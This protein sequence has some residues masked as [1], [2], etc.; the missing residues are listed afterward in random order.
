MAILADRAAELARGLLALAE[1]AKQAL[2]GRLQGCPFKIGGVRV[3]AVLP[4]LGQHG[5]FESRGYGRPADFHRPFRLCNGRHDQPTGD[6]RGIF[7]RRRVAMFVDERGQ[8]GDRR[9]D[10]EPD[11]LV[12]YFLSYKIGFQRQRNRTSEEG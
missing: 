6:R 1:L 9:C 12:V 11:D 5:F 3:E 4:G 7:A 10:E 8:R 2:R